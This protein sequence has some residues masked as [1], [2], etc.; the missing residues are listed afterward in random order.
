MKGFLNSTH[1]GLYKK[2]EGACVLQVVKVLK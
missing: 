1:S 2:Q